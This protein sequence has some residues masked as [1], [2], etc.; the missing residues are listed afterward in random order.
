MKTV[1]SYITEKLKIKKGESYDYYA[2]NNEE[3]KKIIYNITNTTM[4]GRSNILDLTSIDVSEVEY[5]ESLFENFRSETHDTVDISGWD[6]TNASSL[7]KMFKNSSFKKIIGFN[8]LDLSKIKSLRECFCECIELEEIEGIEKIS[9]TN[10]C[11]QINWMFESCEKLQ[12]P[13]VLDWDVSGIEWSSG[14]FSGCKNIEKL[15][16]SK[17]NIKKPYT[18]CKMFYNCE[19]LKSIKGIENWNLGTC[20]DASYMFSNCI[21]LETIGDISNWDIKGV[22]NLELMFD[23]CKNLKCD[24]STWTSFYPRVRKAYMFRGTK[25]KIFIKPKL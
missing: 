4:N 10:Y 15:D 16:L 24:L 21:N 14:A 8:T 12:L 22:K 17:W 2:K 23:Q 9:I 11:N 25:P 19:N 18:F 5:F 7:A 3:L 20:K 13:E 6:V 1:L